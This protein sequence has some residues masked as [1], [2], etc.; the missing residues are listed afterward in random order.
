MRIDLGYGHRLRFAEWSP[1]LSIPANA[2]RYGDIADQFPVTAGA[3]V[4]HDMPVSDRFPEGHCEGYIN[5]DLPLVREHFSGPYW[6]VVTWEP[7][8]L[9]PSLQ[10]HCGDHGYIRDSVWVPA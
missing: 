4:E 8:T 7:L 2:E 3:I 1:D 5:F 10:C 9:S 6:Q